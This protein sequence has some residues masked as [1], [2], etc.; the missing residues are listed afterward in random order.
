[1]FSFNF[2]WVDAKSDWQLQLIALWD[3]VCSPLKG[4]A[5]SEQLCPQRI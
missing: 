1:M 2:D 5:I 3:T 4:K